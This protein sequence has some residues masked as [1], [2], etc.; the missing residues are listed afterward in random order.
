MFFPRASVSFP[1]HCHDMQCTFIVESLNY[2]QGEKLC[3]HNAEATPNYH[4]HPVWVEIWQSRS[5][6]DAMLLSY[7]KCCF[8]CFKAAWEV[9]FTPKNKELSQPDTMSRAS[10]R[11]IFTSSLVYV[12]K[13]VAFMRCIQLGSVGLLG[14]LASC[15]VNSFCVVCRTVESHRGL[16]ASVYL[17]KCQICPG[18]IVQKT[19]VWFMQL[20]SL[21]KTVGAH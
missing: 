7:S 12:P 4:L 3:M 9:L 15:K 2:F 10:S 14:V 17:D 18:I 20:M 21:V 16:L 5:C 19:T 13:K 1:G 8:F 11:V 6:Q